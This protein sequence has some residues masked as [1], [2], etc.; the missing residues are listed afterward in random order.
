MC[1][2][3]QQKE[4]IEAHGFY[5][6]EVKERT[7]GGCGSRIGFDVVTFSGDR[8]PLARVGRC[9]I[10]LSPPPPP[11]PPVFLSPS[12]FSLFISPLSHSQSQGAGGASKHK[13]VFVG[14]YCVELESFE[15][16]A[17]PIL[18]SQTTP[19]KHEG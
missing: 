16:A 7:T 14:K 19:S 13:P 2:F 11:P 9:G 3:L 8:A 12:P 10:S 15:S 5:T 4:G 1:L 6:E 18:Q 17:L